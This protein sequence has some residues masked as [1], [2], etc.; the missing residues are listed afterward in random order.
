MQVCK[1]DLKVTDVVSMSN[2]YVHANSALQPEALANYVDK[3]DGGLGVIHVKSK[4]TALFMKNLLEEAE[5]N[6]YVKAVMRKYCEDQDISPIPARPPFLQFQSK[7]VEA[8][9]FE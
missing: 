9:Q 2:K 4:A 8:N 1:C 5:T 3:K 7:C 6:L